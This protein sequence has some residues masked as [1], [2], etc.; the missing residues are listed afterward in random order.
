[1]HK[2]SGINIE[3]IQRKEK[4]RSA[5]LREKLKSIATSIV[6]VI[7]PYNPKRIFIFGS[8]AGKEWHEG[9]SDIDIAIEGIAMDKLGS[10]DWAIAEKLGTGRFDLVPMEYAAPALKKSIELTGKLIYERKD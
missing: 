1:M 2:I 3:A 6:S 4:K 5:M 7:S 8:L 9:V 10:I